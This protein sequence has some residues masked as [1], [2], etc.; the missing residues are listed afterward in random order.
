MFKRIIENHQVIDI[1]DEITPGCEEAFLYGDATVKFD[2]SCCAVING[3]FY[4]RYD[5]KK[6]IPLV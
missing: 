2:G 5:A 3:E 1:T 4:K 6:G